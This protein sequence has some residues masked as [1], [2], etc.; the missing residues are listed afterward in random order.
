MLV[1]ESSRALA[2]AKPQQI[3]CEGATNIMT[4]KQWVH[5]IRIEIENG[6]LS[7]PKV[8]YRVTFFNNN[9]YA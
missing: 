7:A 6:K 2:H 3:C 9:W 1:E 5:F 8:R 4:N